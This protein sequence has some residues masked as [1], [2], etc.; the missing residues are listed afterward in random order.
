MR[1]KVMAPASSID[2]EI[3]ERAPEL[4]ARNRE[5]PPMG[6]AS[7]KVLVGL[8]WVG[9]STNGPASF[10]FVG[11]IQVAFKELNTNGGGQLIKVTHKLLGFKTC[12]EAHTIGAVTQV[13][14]IGLKFVPLGHEIHPKFTSNI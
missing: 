1:V 10:K 13:P 6:P 14:R 11:I 2:A 9:C 3:T 8:I 7:P 5:F 12:P 4:S